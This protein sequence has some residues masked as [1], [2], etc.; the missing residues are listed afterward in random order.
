MIVINCI[1][2]FPAAA[3]VVYFN[4]F[5]NGVGSEW[6]DSSTDIT[7]VGNRQFLGQFGNE[8]VALTLNNLPAHTEV[9]ISFDLFIIRS[10]SGNEPDIWNLNVSNGPILL[11]TTFNNHDPHIFNSPTPQAYPDNYPDGSHPSFTGASE[12]NALGY[13]FLC[14]PSPGDGV[15]DL[16]MD[17][18]YELSFIFPHF[19]SELVLNFSGA[20]LAGLAS[21]SWG[22]DNVTVEA[23]PE[24]STLLL[25]G[26]GAVMVR[27]R[28]LK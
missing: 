3:Q 14:E 5:E 8:T 24:P 4:N 17:T 9:T 19:A 2:I 20:E 26:L 13:T 16:P 15:V 12:I 28:C 25:I 10:W 7:P 21:A 18:V 1:L 22:L 6:S 23:I 11:H 27:K